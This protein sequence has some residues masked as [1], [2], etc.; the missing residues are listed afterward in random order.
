MSRATVGFRFSAAANPKA[1]V[2]GKL[3]CRNA[4]IGIH[5]ADETDVNL[6]ECVHKAIT[7]KAAYL[8]DDSKLHID[9]CILDFRNNPR[10]LSA[11]DAFVM[12]SREMLGET[13]KLR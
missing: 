10:S 7:S 8:I 3:R 12:E 1:K 4:G 5:L 11:R 9:E 6:T 2:I 13:S